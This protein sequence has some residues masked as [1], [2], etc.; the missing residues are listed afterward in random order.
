MV[1]EGVF[2]EDLFYRL[3]V[4][5]IKLPP[6]RDRPEDIPL[7]AAHFTQKYALAGEQAKKITPQ[8]MEA[9]LQYEWPGNIRQ[10]EN[11]IERACVTSTD[12]TI[13]AENLPP[14]ILQPKTKHAAAPQQVDLDRPLPDLL[15]DMTA[16]LEENYI[17]EA[18]RKT[19][20][21]VGRC[22]KL[23]GMSRRSITTKIAHYNID[24]A[25]FK[26]LV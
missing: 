20:G 3:N 4:V 21:D 17:R 14:E 13:R 11:A 12:G 9:M 5:R 26:E 25:T 2:R 23:C 19:H 10:L 6:L 1:Q 18:L 7:L 22:A 15:R 24:K 8:A 16:A